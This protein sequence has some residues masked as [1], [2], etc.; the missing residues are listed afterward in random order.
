MGAMPEVT[1]V[2]R[3]P[4]STLKAGRSAAQP[5][6]LL[7][8]LFVCIALTSDQ[9]PGQGLR[10]L[11]DPRHGIFVP[12]PLIGVLGGASEEGGGHAELEGSG[13]PTP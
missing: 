2:A 11:R 5:R 6:D 12:V 7:I 1:R 4:C 8:Y 10:C 13:M 9:L 3:G